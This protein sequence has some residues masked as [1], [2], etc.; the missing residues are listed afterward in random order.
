MSVHRDALVAEREFLLESLDDLEAERRDG[1][2]DDDTYRLLHDDYTARA[3]A[4]IRSL[5]DGIERPGTRAP[6]PRAL[7]LVTIGAIVVFCAVAAVLLTR[8][9]GERAPGGTIT[10]NDGLAPRSVPEDREAAL[11]AAAEADPRSYD[12]RVAYARL[13]RDRQDFAG[14][15]EQY[16][17]AARLDPSQAEPLTYRGWITALV[18]RELDDE[19]TRRELLGRATADLDRAVTVDPDYG[20]VYVFKG[21]VLMRILDRPADA[22]APLQRY[23]VLASPDDPMRP[24]VLELLAEAHA[25]ATSRQEP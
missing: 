9:I 21:I 2:I 19:S 12:A 25:A 1:N 15:I 3:A 18:A 7:R 10:G 16:T 23:L 17:A 14:A 20:P 13:L 22:V 4:V 11:K 6:E 24:Q 8:A 5:D